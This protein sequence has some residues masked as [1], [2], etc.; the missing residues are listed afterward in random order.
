[1]RQLFIITFCF[2]FIQISGQTLNSGEYIAVIGKA[3]DSYIPDMVTFNFSINATEKKQNDAVYKMNDQ[4][5]K[6]IDIISRLGYNTKE[7]KLSNYELGE[8]IDYSGDK[9]KNN[10]Y[11]ASLSF[12][13]EI[14]YTEDSFNTLLDSISAH[15][16]PDLNFTYTSTFSDELQDKIKKE[17]ITK[18]S[19]NAESIAKTLA[20][21]RNVE[22]GNIFS[23]EYTN[24]NFSLY[25]QGILPPPPPPM[26]VYAEQMSAPRISSS[27]SMRGIFNSQE[28]RIIYR[29]KK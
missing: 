21:A 13:L 3:T 14:K 12:E 24:S 16:I 29:I 27:I 9:P 17:L 1:M 19:D 20:R 6:V 25:G 11:R 2:S 4:S 28:V 26:E 8:D 10:G 18:A 23:I 22:L 5:E 15:K 7:I